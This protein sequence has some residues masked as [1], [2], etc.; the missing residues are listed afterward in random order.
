M[1]TMM[2]WRLIIKML[3]I[4]LTRT[5]RNDDAPLTKGAV[6]FAIFLTRCKRIFL[7]WRIWKGYSWC[8][9][10]LWHS[11]PSRLRPSGSC[12][13]FAVYRHTGGTYN[14]NLASQRVTSTAACQPRQ[15]IRLY[16]LPFI[17]YLSSVLHKSSLKYQNSSHDS[18]RD[19][20]DAEN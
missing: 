17:I 8:V 2:K 19:D 5:L 15:G 12:D 16:L 10:K 7:N 20:V 1:M 18:L 4:G 13:P 6:S 9:L 3:F 11:M 14:K